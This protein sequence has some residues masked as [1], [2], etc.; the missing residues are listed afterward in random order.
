MDNYLKIIKVVGWMVATLFVVGGCGKSEVKQPATQVVAKVNS[1]EISVHQVNDV[2]VRTPSVTNENVNQIKH[3]IL[4]KLIDQQ[5]AVEQ[6][7]ANK[8]DRNPNVMRAI[9]AAKRDILARAYYEQVASALTITPPDEARRYYNAHPELFSARRV[10]SLQELLVGPDALPTVQELLS[11]NKSFQEIV[12]ALDAR[13]LKYTASA[14]IRPA[15]QLPLTAVA[16]IHGIK[17]GQIG[18]VDSAEGSMVMH[19]V[20]SQTQPVSEEQALPSIQ[21][22]L[23]NQRRSEAVEQNIKSMREKARIERIGEFAQAPAAIA[24]PAAVST[25]DITSATVDAK[26]V[27]KG[28]AGLK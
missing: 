3:G 17:D 9:E 25:P 15:E 1:A 28:V 12:S 26:S 8:L 14:G 11:R 16:K 18:I 21:T 23:T 5:L 6:A 13:K 20:A 10:Y 2:L 7:E 19:V 27:A 24:P 22:F 4:D